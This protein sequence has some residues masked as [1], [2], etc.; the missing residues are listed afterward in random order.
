[1][2]K[3]LSAVTIPVHAAKYPNVILHHKTV[4]SR[5]NVQRS[6]PDEGL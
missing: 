5:V 6:F 1:M 2:V 3:N 4:K